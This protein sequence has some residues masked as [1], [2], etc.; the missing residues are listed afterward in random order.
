MT[1]R[2]LPPDA[3]PADPP[4]LPHGWRQDAACRTVDPE[5]FFPTGRKDTIARRAAEAAAVRVCA[6]CP[7]RLPCL[8]VAVHR[9]EGHGVWGGLPAPFYVGPVKAEEA[10]G[11]AGRLLGDVP[12]E[13]G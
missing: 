2:V 11:V 13:T 5:A 12:A 3:V 1:A 6:G 9:R 10:V 4:G 7:V 8:A